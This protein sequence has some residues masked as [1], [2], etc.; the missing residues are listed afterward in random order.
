[1]RIL[2]TGNKGFIGSRIENSLREIGADYIGI[3]YNEDIPSSRF[4]LILHFGAR[5]LIRNSK[6]QPYEYFRDNVD[7]TM[8]VLEKCRTE[9]STIVYPTSG[10]VQSPTNPY[11]LTKRQG[12]EWV[13]LYSSLYGITSYI[14]K[15]YNIY[16]ETSRK[17]AIFLFCSAAIKGEP[18]IMYGD[19]THKRDF[20]HVDDLVSLIIE[21][22]RQN[23]PS[24]TYEV[25]TGLATSIKDLLTLV[26]KIAGKKLIVEKQDYVMNEPEE[27]YAKKTILKNPIPLEQGVRMVFNSLKDVEK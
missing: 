12:E 6:K 4:D 22:I 8:K 1:M 20:V 16:G 14:L 9:H 19:G 25:G 3:D 15:L 7:F 26:E 10:S 27:L 2:L 5:T 13:S 21:I 17:G 11:S 18:V 24:G 23:L